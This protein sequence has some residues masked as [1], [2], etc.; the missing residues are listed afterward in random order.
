[1][2]AILKKDEKCTGKKYD[3]YIYGTPYSPVNGTVYILK[4]VELPE[5]ILLK[6]KEE[7]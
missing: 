2:E 4:G 5:S 7:K 6:F 1:M 3:R